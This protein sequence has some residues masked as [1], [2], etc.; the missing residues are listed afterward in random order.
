[1]IRAT[2]IAAA[3]GICALSSQAQNPTP[4]PSAPVAKPAPAQPTPPPKA[5]RA[6]VLPTEWSDLDMSDLQD[7]MDALKDMHLERLDALKDMRLDMEI[8]PIAPIEM[9]MDFDYAPGAFTVDATMAPM[10]FDFDFDF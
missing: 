7:R 2:F 4:A 10:D 5:K 3:L 8:P 9:D 6:P 1:M